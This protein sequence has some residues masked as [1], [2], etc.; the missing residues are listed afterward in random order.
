VRKHCHIFFVRDVE[1]K[2]RRGAVSAAGAETRSWR[3]TRRAI[4]RRGYYAV[5]EIASASSMRQGPVISAES[6]MMKLN[7]N[8]QITSTNNQIITKYQ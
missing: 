1:K 2:Y 8:N 6:P 4:C 5:M 3:K 7:E